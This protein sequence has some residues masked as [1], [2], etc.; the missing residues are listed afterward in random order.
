MHLIALALAHLEAPSSFDIASLL[1]RGSPQ[2]VLQH[3][4]G[5]CPAGIKRALKHLPTQVLRQ[6]NYRLLIQLLDD[7]AAAKVLNHADQINDTAI[8][9]LADLPQKLRVGRLPLPEAMPPAT[10]G[11][12]RRLDRV[13]RF[14]RSPGRGDCLASYGSAIDGG[15]CAVYLWEER[16]TPCCLP[17]QSAWSVRLAPG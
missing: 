9:V 8:R 2:Q 6:Q 10:V 12:A 17:D 13:I 7:L 3:A 11:N 1:I 14:A 15:S 5:R 16:G 4:L